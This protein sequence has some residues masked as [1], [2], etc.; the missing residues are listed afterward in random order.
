M[1]HYFKPVLFFVLAIYLTA[2][3]SPIKQFTQQVSE[4]YQI[5]AENIHRILEQA[6]I[7][8]KV[9]DIMS[10]K[11]RKARA[12]QDWETY[13]RNAL[14]PSRLKAGLNFLKIHAKTFKEAEKRYGVP[15]EIIASIIGIETRYG[16]YMGKFKTLDALYT[17]SFYH[18]DQSRLK[19]IE[20]FRNQLA[21]LIALHH[22]NR[23]DIH[24]TYGSFAGAVGLP[25]FMPASIIRFA[26][27]HQ[28]HANH[29]IDLSNRPEDAIMS[30]G[31]YL[32]EHG[33]ISG[34]P[35]FVGTSN[36]PI[37]RSISLANPSTQ[38]YE[39]RL[40]TENFDVIRKY[41]FSDFYVTAVADFANE[42]KR[43]SHEK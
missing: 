30:V 35:V 3:S 22:Q 13:R 14:H 33:W 39:L 24:Q 31:N 37:K 21:A 42:L 10:P 5:P 15:A 8:T 19:R 2:C 23:L 7:N 28:G 20:M 1:T 34:L 29:Q 40:A 38:H 18:P 12:A 11:A 27:N 9:Q 4:Q 6:Q 26:V 16:Q 25:Q 17:L 32:K 36:A 43:R 41:N